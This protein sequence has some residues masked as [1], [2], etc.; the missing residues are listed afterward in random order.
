[1]REETDIFAISHQT[2][3]I[4]LTQPHDWWT[5]RHFDGKISLEMGISQLNNVW[6]EASNQ[7]LGQR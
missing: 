4:S 6:I 7:G 1:M 3:Q 2:S 5:N